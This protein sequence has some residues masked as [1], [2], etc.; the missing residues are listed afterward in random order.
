MSTLIN[1]IKTQK[2]NSIAIVDDNGSITY[3]ELLSNILTAS[4]TIT[5]AKCIA[6]SLD[7]CI[8]WIIWDLAAIEA[9]VPCVPIPSFFTHEQISYIIK[10]TSASHLITSTGLNHTGIYQSTEILP[11]RTAKIT[12]TSG[13]T[14]KAK[15]VCLDLNGMETVALSINK[16][17]PLRYAKNHLCIL[18]LSILLENVAGVYSTLLAGGTVYAP[19]LKTIGFEHIFQPNFS[20]LIQYMREMNIS[21]SIVVPEILR[22][23]I[24]TAPFLPDLEFIAVGGSKISPSLLTSARS[25]GLPVY[26]GYGLSECG[27]VVSLNSPGSDSLGTV[28]KILPH[29]QLSESEGEIVIQNPAFLGYIGDIQSGPFFTGDL[30]FITNDG[31][32]CIDGRKKNTIITSYGRNICPEWIESNLLLNPEILQAVVY[33]D[34]Q[35]FLSALIVPFHH[36]NNISE[37]IHSANQSLPEYAQIKNYRLVKPFSIDDGTLTATGRP[38]RIQILEKYTNQKEIFDELL[39]SSC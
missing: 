3:E 24:Q 2:K 9:N 39:R 18:P 34:S 26:E 14:G 30:G 7:N 11:L 31:F 5:D 23:L 32:L 21:S 27:S 4:K 29:V 35:P 20:R 25:I 8:D 22:G 12:F 36:T 15:G 19:S 13:T 6:L 38:K 17:L 37:I 1:S 28:G 10:K 33:G 16:I